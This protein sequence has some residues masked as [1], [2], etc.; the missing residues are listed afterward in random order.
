M[1]KFAELLQPADAYYPG[2]LSGQYGMNEVANRVTDAATGRFVAPLVRGDGLERALSSL[3]L[4]LSPRQAIEHLRS[5]STVSALVPV[6]Q[7][8]QVV[9]TVGAL[10]SVANLGVSCVGFALVLQ[11]LG[12][13]EGKLDEMLTKL[14]V[15][16]DSV[17]QLQAHADALSLARVR[18]AGDSLDR[19]L[20]ADSSS[21]RQELAARARDLFQGSRAFY[22][23]LWRHV[24]PWSQ[25][26]VPVPTALEMQ[27]RFVVC[28]LGEIQAEF[29]GGDMGAFRHAVHSVANDVRTQMALDAPS[30]LRERSDAAC[31]QG[32][33]ELAQFGARIAELTTQLRVARDVTDWTGK[34]LEGFAL[35]ADLPSELGVEPYEIVQ[36][37]RVAKGDGLFVLQRPQR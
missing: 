7:T 31:A 35:D 13:I 9:G 27:S 4:T 10:A 34:R 29:I 17:R 22:L 30:A 37:V 32:V 21:K 19:A 6:L 25:P 15:L 11:R 36:A 8:M 18:S 1:N 14:D 16:Q 26:K 2:L 23:E 20:S 3:P 33:D 24:R 5:V 12:R 28:A